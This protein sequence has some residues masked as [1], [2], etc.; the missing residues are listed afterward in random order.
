MS[1]I[2]RWE[3]VIEFSRGSLWVIIGQNGVKKVGWNR[4]TSSLSGFQTE[5]IRDWIPTCISRL[6][7]HVSGTHVHTYEDIPLDYGELSDFTVKVL[8]ICAQIPIGETRTYGE[9]AVEVGSPAGA[10]A[11]GQV[12]RR[13]PFPIIV[14]CHRVIGST[15][16]NSLFYSGAGPEMKHYLLGLEGVKIPRVQWSQ[17]RSL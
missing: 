5:P 6:K 13:N 12:M 17:K 11:V 16:S 8:K 9:V 3:F 4:P 1:T 15:P 7:E 14:P 2:P 10:R